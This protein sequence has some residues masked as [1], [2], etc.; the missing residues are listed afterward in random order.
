MNAPRNL[1][2]N[3]RSEI[4]IP[5]RLG[6][7]R[8]VSLVSTML[9]LSLL[10]VLAL[11][12]ASLAVNERRTAFNDLSHT[13]SLVAADSGGEAAIAWLML[14]NRPPRITD[15][16]TGKVRNQIM[17]TMASTSNQDF[18][19]DVRMRPDPNPALT[20]MMRPRPGYDPTRY[21]DF[22]YDVDAA[23]AAG[24]DGRSDVSVIVTKLTQLNYN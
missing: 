3:S 1:T 17:T 11:V 8:G 20:F 2:T 14:S 12:A 21:M 13:Q 16:A 9:A 19:F 24:V 15:M 5:V 6:N 23:G 7:D 18:S 22:F 4:R 10:A